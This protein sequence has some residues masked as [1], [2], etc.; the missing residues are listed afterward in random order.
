MQET[1]FWP[2]M[3]DTT[4]DPTKDLSSADTHSLSNFTGVVFKV[5]LNAV[6]EQMTSHRVDGD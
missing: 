2:A 4:I 1:D 6:L 5:D 3:W